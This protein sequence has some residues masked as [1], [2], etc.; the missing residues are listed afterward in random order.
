MA[1]PGDYIFGTDDAEIRRLGQQHQLWSE[2]CH[3]HW[4]RAGFGEGQRLLDLG[5]GPGFA[6]MDLAAI[7]GPEGHVLAVEPEPRY[8]AALEAELV[9]STRPRAS[10]TL[11]LAT[12]EATPL[13]SE[14]FDGAYA[15]WVLTFVPDP[16]AL[17]A[18]IFA[19]LRPGGALAIL[20]YMQWPTLAWGP[21]QETLEVVRAAILE[22][23]A[24]FGTDMAV[25][26][27]LP[28]LL[29]EL[30]FELVEVEPVVRLARPAEPFWRWPEAW[31]QDFLP[32]VVEA[33]HLSR[34]D[35]AAFRE[36]WAENRAHPAGWFL[37]PTLVE[38]VARRPEG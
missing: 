36:E 33:G 13:E 16:A 34:A 5:A 6:T 1:R 20:D 21:H 35:H 9:G 29:T 37:T 19:A 27:R 24:A 25:G 38:I 18:R 12:A 17:L 26:Q 11:E 7:A 2:R 15:R 28:G 23:F 31:L 8:A 30:G 14:H 10:V 32:K 22:K 3:A 4:R